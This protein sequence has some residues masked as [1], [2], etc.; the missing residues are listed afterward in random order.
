MNSESESQTGN[1]ESEENVG[2]KESGKNHSSLNGN[3]FSS[4]NGNLDRP[5]SPSKESK[6]H[7]TSTFKK[8]LAKKMKHR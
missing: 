4:L 5:H 1:S 2:L 3:S 6:I 8:T 7:R